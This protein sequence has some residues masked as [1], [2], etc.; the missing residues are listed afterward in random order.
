LLSKRRTRLQR[1]GPHREAV[2]NTIEY[3][4][5]YCVNTLIE[6]AQCSI[7][8]AS[9]KHLNHWWD[10]NASSYKQNALEAFQ[11]WSVMGRP[12]C[13]VE[14]NRMKEAKKANKNYFF[15]AKNRR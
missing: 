4:N 9:L 15:K 13:G 8:K 11:I 2:N 7:P 14:F 1:C 12:L 5:N 3:W 6:A 10:G